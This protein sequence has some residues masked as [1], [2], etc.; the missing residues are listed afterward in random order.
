MT[1]SPGT[2]YYVAVVSDSAVQD[3]GGFT[4]ALNVNGVST[5]GRYLERASSFP[6]PS[7]I[8]SGM[9]DAL[10]LPWFSVNE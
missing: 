7:S 8:T 1:F 2:D 3:V 6:L 10:Y 9:T 5:N 4:A